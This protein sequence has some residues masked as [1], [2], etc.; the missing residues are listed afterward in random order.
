MFGERTGKVVIAVE[1]RT[2]AK[3]DIIVLLVIQHGVYGSNA[4]HT[5]RRGRQSAMQIGIVWRLVLQVAV[6]YAPQTEIL[7][8]VLYRRV[9]LQGYAL[10]QA[11]HV[12][13]RYARHLVRLACL[14]IDDRGKRRHLHAVQAAALAFLVTLSRPELLILL[15]HAVDE[16]LGRHR[17]VE[18]IRIGQE[19]RE[20]RQRRREPQPFGRRPIHKCRC[21]RCRVGLDLARELARKLRGGLDVVHR[22]LDWGLQPQFQHAHNVD[23]AH[24]LL[25]DI[26]SGLKGIGQLET[27]CI[28]VEGPLVADIDPDRI[29]NLRVG[30]ILVDIQVALLAH[31][32]A[33]ERL[34]EPP[35]R[36]NGND[37]DDGDD[38]DDNFFHIHNIRHALPSP[39]A[40]PISTTI[41]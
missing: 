39:A 7:H 24:T 28:D 36:R 26:M 6:E 16:L 19:Y 3:I 30:V 33:I 20:H 29:G 21:Q 12:D 14:L 35:C 34:I 23:D 17:P 1:G 10:T 18:L 4:R 5:Y 38:G 11:V 22:H 31:A 32:A 41:C 13:T 25:H 9:G 37:R 8:R 27:A 15:I 40:M 2:R